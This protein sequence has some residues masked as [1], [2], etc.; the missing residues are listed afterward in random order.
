MTNKYTE[1]IRDWQYDVI[2]RAMKYGFLLTGIA[3]AAKNSGDYKILIA[4]AMGCAVG[5]GMQRYTS[6]YQKKQE[7]IVRNPTS[8][9][10]LKLEEE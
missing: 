6:L 4:C 7:N 10:E 2:G 5:E 3:E 8:I 1:R 9:L